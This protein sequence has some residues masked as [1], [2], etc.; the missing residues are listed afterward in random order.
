MKGTKDREAWLM[1]AVRQEPRM[2]SLFS[3]LLGVRIDLARTK[4]ETAQD[5]R[6]VAQQQGSIRE[7]RT[8]LRGISV[9]RNEDVSE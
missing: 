4:L 1:T 6:E 3:E 5:A 2:V 9:R 7:L 8:I